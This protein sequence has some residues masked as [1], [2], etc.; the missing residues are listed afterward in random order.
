MAWFVGGDERYD[1]DGWKKGMFSNNNYN[2]HKTNNDS[3]SKA[4]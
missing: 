2:T 1:P 4:V 3:S